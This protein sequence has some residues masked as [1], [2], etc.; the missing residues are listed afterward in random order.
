MPREFKIRIITEADSAG[1]RQ[2]V[3]D[4]NAV[5]ES[6]VSA[7]KE[8]GQETEKLT[9][10]KTELRHMLREV[11]REF[12]LLGMA[13]RLAMNPLVGGV[14]LLIGALEM[15][16]GI[17]E[18]I[19]K[20]LNEG[21]GSGNYRGHLDELGKAAEDSAVKMGEFAAKLQE[22]ATAQESV[23]DRTQESIDAI[24]AQ[25]VA[26]TELEN[27]QKAAELARVDMLEKQ[28]K[29]SGP[30]AIEKRLAVEDKFSRRKLVQDINAQDATIEARRKELARTQHDAAWA[31]DAADKAEKKAL[32]SKSYA[33]QYTGLKDKTDK[34]LA[35]VEKQIKSLT[36]GGLIVPGESNQLNSAF[37]LQQQLIARR[38]SLQATSA[39]KLR[40]DASVDEQ[41][42]QSARTLAMG[43]SGRV[44]ELSQSIPIEQKSANTRYAAAGQTASVE[45][46]TRLYNAAGESATGHEQAFKGLEQALKTGN[47]NISQ[48]VN[49]V[50]RY[51]DEQN[52]L[53][54]RIGKIEGKSGVGGPAPSGR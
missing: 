27:A 7:N 8:V 1:A 48:L 45:S 40:L 11:G 47:G 35:E 4:M 41:E 14:G 2:T 42:A 18:Q 6:G 37:S 30:E 36:S 44:N 17:F 25:H 32:A 34:D 16:K 31:E 10:K 5:K 38:G 43:L 50:N 15:L 26:T 49:I 29:L 23:K 46:V 33:I 21:I 52:R 51:T 19:N 24:K 54:A 9:V 12:P 39:T 28:H 22:V 13:G 20:K 53:S 3:T